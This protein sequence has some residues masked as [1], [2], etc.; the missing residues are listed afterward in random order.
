MNINW[1]WREIATFV[2]AM[3]VICGFF[4]IVLLLTM[5]GKL[6]A[7]QQDFIMGVIT[8]NFTAS[9]GFYVSSS[10]GSITKGTTIED[11]AK[12]AAGVNKEKE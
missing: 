1:S 2:V 4:S 12:K 5:Q 9:V 10:Q 6:S 8:G 3:S 11:I 7:G